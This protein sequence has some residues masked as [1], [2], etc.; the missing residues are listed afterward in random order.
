MSTELSARTQQH[1][2]ALFAPE[3]QL[4]ASAL[5]IEQCGTNLPS[6]EALDPVALER[7][8]FA[9]LKVSGGQL[10]KLKEAV[11][12]AQT[13]WRDLLVAAGFAHDIRAHESWSPNTKS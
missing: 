13:D 2:A 4:Q 11:A 1:V 9:A 12:L 7:Y 6:L 5:I 3:L 10:D 8:R